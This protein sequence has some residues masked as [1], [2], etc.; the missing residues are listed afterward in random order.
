[1]TRML[2]GIAALMIAGAATLP[3]P[4]AAIEQGITKVQSTDLS[5][6]HR[7]GRHYGHYGHRYWGPR[8][9]Y[10]HRFW[11]RAATMVIDTGVRAATATMDTRIATAT[12]D[13]PII[14]DRASPSASAR[15][16]SVCSSCAA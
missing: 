16:V 5:S 4:A 3:V 14:A 10:A 7:Y 9:Y 13:I 12:T 11:G 8:R 15:S 6:R 2:T 1:M